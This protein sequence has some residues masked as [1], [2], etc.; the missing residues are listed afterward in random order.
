[1]E[2]KGNYKE[3]KKLV[4]VALDA[5]VSVFVKGHPGVG[6]S[7]M[8]R[9]LASEYQLELV[10][11]RLSQIDPSELVGIKMIDKET[12]KV[13][14]YYPEWAPFN[15]PKFIFFD[16]FNAGVT[17][18]HQAVAYEI[19]LDRKISNK[20]FHP[21][22]KIMAAGNLAEDNAIVTSLSSALNNRFVHFVLEPDVDTWL[23][24]ARNS[25][26]SPEMRGYIAFMGLKGLYNYKEDSDAF[27]T[28]RS[29]AN[30]DKLYQIA[31]DRN[32]TE[33]EI[34]MLVASAIG[35]GDAVQF[36]EFVKIFKEIDINKIIITGELP[37]N[38]EPSFLYALVYAL[39]NHISSKFTPKEIVKYINPISKL[40]L[41]IPQEYVV[42]FL[43]ELSNNKE[44]FTPFIK[45]LTNNPAF[46]SIVN[47]IISSLI[48]F[49]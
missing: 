44:I 20:R 4:K 35:Y 23:E 13:K 1:M 46:Q 14:H 45:H 30:A 10:D 29:V 17:K 43:K 25:G 7:A 15:E 2:V 27:P 21:D 49:A 9:E 41:S 33:Y 16:E 31:K 24:W 5:G 11:I 28:P 18:L 38:K 36:M 32:L 40:L 6:K 42:V 39:S 34:K 3:I 19:V 8:A 12:N 47:N 48:E 37:Q 26:I 22:T